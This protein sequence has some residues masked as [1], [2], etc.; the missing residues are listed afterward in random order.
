MVRQFPLWVTRVRPFPF[1][2][3]VLQLHKATIPISG[4]HLATAGKEVVIPMATCTARICMNALYPS[5]EF[6][7]FSS[8][9]HAVIL[10]WDVLSDADAD[11]SRNIAWN[12]LSWSPKQQ[13]KRDLSGI[14]LFLCASSDQLPS[15]LFLYPIIRYRL[16]PLTPAFPRGSVCFCTTVKKK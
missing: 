15:R 3:V 12:R 13:G 14:K 8:N 1:Y 7:V 9:S 11:N 6:I 2:N 16:L 4:Y 10:G 5:V